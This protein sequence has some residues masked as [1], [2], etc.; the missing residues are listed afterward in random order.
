MSLMQE[1]YR[2]HLHVVMINKHEQRASIVWKPHHLQGRM[3][4]R[5]GL[6]GEV[7]DQFVTDVEVC[8]SDIIRSLQEKQTAGLVQ[9]LQNIN[10]PSH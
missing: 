8:R 4:V 2:K 6:T 7:E 3:H 5:Q 10:Q 1:T 9:A